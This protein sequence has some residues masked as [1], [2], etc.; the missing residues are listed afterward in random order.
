MNNHVAPSL[1]ALADRELSVKARAGHVALLLGALTMAIVIGSLWLTEP[2]LPLRTQVAFGAM[3]LIGLCW[4]LYAGWVLRSRRVLLAFQEV[5][6][7]RL[8]V[9]FCSAALAG[10]LA[11]AIGEGMR[12][13]WSAAAMFALLLLVA[14]AMLARAR[15][16]L[17]V[18]TA[19]RAALEQQLRR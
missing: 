19:R 7:S 6:A 1:A 16:R 18:L 15:R 11:L 10:A 8:A 4:S 13:A 9:A 3:T 5:V 2:A 12:A 17:N 14:G